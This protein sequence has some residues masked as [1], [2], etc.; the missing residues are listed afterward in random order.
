MDSYNYRDL[1][2]NIILNPGDLIVDELTGFVGILIRKERLI[3]IMTLP[4]F[5]ILIY[6]K[7]KD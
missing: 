3:E 2:D 1:T 6:L 5:Q 7:K 4:K